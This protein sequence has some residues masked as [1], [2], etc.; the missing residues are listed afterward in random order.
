MVN[1]DEVENRCRYFACADKAIL[2]YYTTDLSQLDS[3]INN[4]LM[5][6]YLTINKDRLQLTV[7]LSVTVL[8][9]VHINKYLA[10]IVGGRLS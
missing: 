9:E 3:I 1:A 8:K 4:D 7:K 2:E 5:T 10:F 6:Q